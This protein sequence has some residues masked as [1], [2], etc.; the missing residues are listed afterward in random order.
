MPLFLWSMVISMTQVAAA[1]SGM[2][3]L[4]DSLEHLI[5]NST[6][7][8]SKIENYDALNRLLLKLNDRQTLLEKAEEGLILSEK[9]GIS[10]W[11]V[12][13]TLYKAIAIDISGSP[14]EAIPLYMN[15]LEMAKLTNEKELEA[16][17]YMNI[18]AC[19]YYIGDLHLGLKN[20]LDAYERSE[21]MKKVDLAKLLNNIGIIYRLQKK[22]LR[23]EEI[24]LK[25]Y[26]LKEELQDSLGMATSLMNLGL[27]NYRIK[28]K[29]RKAI[30]YLKKSYLLYEKLKRPYDMASCSTSLGE[31]YLA[32]KNIPAAKK[33]LSKAWR[34]FEEHPSQQYS[35]SSLNLL[36]QIAVLE[37]D[38]ELAET[39][40]EKALELAVGSG[41]KKN[42][43]E[44]LF[45]LSE[46][47]N[48]LGKNQK[49]YSLL[50]ESYTINDTLKQLKGIEAME[51]MQ[52]KFDVG[53][54]ESELQINRLKLNERTLERNIFLIGISFLA[55]CTLFIFFFLRS[56]IR[57]NKKITFQKEEI[58][59]QR[60]NELQ[61]KN[62]LLALS[63]M[64]EGQEAERMRIAK[65]LH[66]SLGGLLSTVKA[67]FTSI[68]SESEQQQKTHLAE[69]TNRLIDEACIEV[70][71]ISHNMIPNVL[72]LS[73]LPEA[74][75]DF[76]DGLKNE[77][78]SVDLDVNDFPEQMSKT[79]QVMLFRIVQEAVSN[80]RKH[81]DA[82]SILIQI[83]KANKRLSLIIE[84][85]GKGFDHTEAVASR[86]VGLKNI[87]SRVEF[88]NGSIDWNTTLGEGTTITINIPIT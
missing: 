80:I 27:V 68:Q 71:R 77:G 86:G 40:L 51:E 73:G 15:G 78:Y 83:F 76:S 28:G 42:H 30:D 65:D 9:L 1:Q 46:I 48:A 67:H 74:L 22:H 81:A 12:Q 10:K 82:K 41:A 6:D 61:Q 20:Y 39:Y 53:E 87:N 79:K 35:I 52:A 47:K 72:T 49:A 62:K 24:Y 26:R 55:V 4:K 75:E 88:L 84:D 14:N 59:M 11:I 37:K 16:K 32:L 8:V 31:V 34:Y 60:I 25:S 63:G 54:K 45:A 66:D 17:Y 7:D 56:K 13:M 5:S 23:A 33:E 36:S 69:K 43:G 29:E 85:D 2:L 58:Q 44:I 3:K 57:A 70:R 64:I 19:Y 18:G 50:K 38:Y 21:A